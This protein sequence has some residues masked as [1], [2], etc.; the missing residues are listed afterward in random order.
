MSQERNHPRRARNL[1]IASTAGLAG[2]VTIMLAVGALLLGLFLDAQV[3]LR[4]P[5]TILLVV[6]S[7]PVSLFLM[8]RI[9]LSAAQRLPPPR[10]VSHEADALP[11]RESMTEE[12]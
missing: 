11:G 12:E 1:S 10:V 6:L 3:G 4:G 2:C 8:V 9:A 7:V 5:F